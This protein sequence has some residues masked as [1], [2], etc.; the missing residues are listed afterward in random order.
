MMNNKKYSRQVGSQMTVIPALGRW[1]Q[2][3]QCLKVIFGNVESYEI[4][5]IIICL[6]I[7]KLGVLEEEQ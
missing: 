3:N 6:Q 4:S 2:K 5:Y 1:S 7:V